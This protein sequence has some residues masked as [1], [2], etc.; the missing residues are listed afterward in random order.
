M[1]Q[2]KKQTELAV[3]AYLQRMSVVCSCPISGVNHVK[4]SNQFALPVIY[5]PT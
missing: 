1:L 4:A 3:K 5:F 2:D